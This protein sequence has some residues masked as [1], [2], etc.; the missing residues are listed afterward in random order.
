MNFFLEAASVENPLAVNSSME[1][2]GKLLGAVMYFVIPI[3]GLVLI[4]SGLMF[5]FA[6]G[7]KIKIRRAIYNLTYVALAIALILGSYMIITVVSN[8]IGAIIRTK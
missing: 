4:L 7:N 5:I 2:L 6:R 1:F 3:L 8:T